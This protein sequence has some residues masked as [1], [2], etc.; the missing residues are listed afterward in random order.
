M[1]FAFGRVLLF[2]DA[3]WAGASDV[4]VTENVLSSVGVG[5]AIIDGI[6]RVDGAWQLEEPHDFRL[7]VYLGQVL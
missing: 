2:S 6:L 3:G 7:D 5:L 1:R 4:R